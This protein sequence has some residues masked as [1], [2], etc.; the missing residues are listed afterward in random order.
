MNTADPPIRCPTFPP[1]AGGASAMPYYATIA[2][3]II[4]VFNY[5]GWN[6]VLDAPSD[7]R[8]MGQ[9]PH[10][11]PEPWVDTG[12]APHTPTHYPPLGTVPFPTHI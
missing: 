4:T 8:R 6:C 12:A 7:L 11:L 2:C 5:C 10:A 1:P 9:E 3:W